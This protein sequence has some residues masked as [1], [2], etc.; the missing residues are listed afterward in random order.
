MHLVTKPVPVA[1]HFG[2]LQE[3]S[4]K[5]SQNILLSTFSAHPWLKVVPSTLFKTYQPTMEF[6]GVYK[7]RSLSDD[8]SKLMKTMG[9]WNLSQSITLL[10]I[11]FYNPTGLTEPDIKLVMHPKNST[12]LTLMKNKDASITYITEITMAPHMNFTI[13]LKVQRIG[14]FHISCLLIY[15]RLLPQPIF[16]LARLLNS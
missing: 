16:R 5:D 7:L 10:C 3:R 14:D 12:T 11:F 9:M 8:F 4:I 1:C 2:H 15:S 13:T 6:D